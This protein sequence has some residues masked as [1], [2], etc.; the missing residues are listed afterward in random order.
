MKSTRY[1]ALC[2]LSTIASTVGGF[3]LEDHKLFDQRDCLDA[4][5]SSVTFKYRGHRGMGYDNGYSSAAFFFT[6]AWTRDFQP[7]LD[8]RLHIF[9]NGYYASNLGAGIRFGNENNP[10]IFGIN[11]YYDYR[12]W[13]SLE[14]N[15]FGAGIELLSKIFSARLNGYYPI[16][17]KTDV[18]AA[19]FGG[20]RNF[21]I[22]VN[23]SVRAALPSADFEIGAGNISTWEYLD[24][25]VALGSYYLFKQNANPKGIGNALGGRA[26]LDIKIGWL[27]IG[28]EY[29]YDKLFRSRAVAYGN[30][31]IPFGPKKRKKLRW[32]GAIKS[33]S[34]WCKPFRNF[35]DVR[36]QPVQ[37]NEI[38]PMINKEFSIDIKISNSS[39]SL[40][41]FNNIIFVSN[42][43]PAIGAG[44][45]S[46]GNGSF[47]DP[48][49]T[50]AQAQEHS[51]P[52]DM[53]YLLAGNETTD[54]YD[55]G[56][57][58]K[59][60]QIFIGSGNSF[61][62]G[63]VLVPALTPGVN[64]KM[65]NISGSA[66][67]AQDFCTID[68]IDIVNPN[69]AAVAA[70]GKSFVTIQ[71]CNMQGNTLN[72]SVLFQGG[73]GNLTIQ[74]NVITTTRSL[75]DGL[76][77][78]DLVAASTNTVNIL[79]NKITGPFAAGVDATWSNVQTEEASPTFV[80]R[81]N[82][83]IITNNV[84]GTSAQFQSMP[85]SLNLKMFSNTLNGKW[86]PIILADVPQGTFKLTMSGNI[87]GPGSGDT[88]TQP[89]FVNCTNLTADVNISGNY[90]IQSQ[91]GDQL[92]LVFETTGQSSATFNNNHIIKTNTVADVSTA[93]LLSVEN[94][95]NMYIRNNQFTAQKPTAGG[96]SITTLNSGSI[97]SGNT[98]SNFL[99]DL[100]IGTAASPAPKS[101]SSIIN[102]YSNPG[103]K[104]TISG[105]SSSVK[106]VVYVQAG[107]C[108]GDPGL[109]NMNKPNAN[110]ATTNV[111]LVCT[112]PGEYPACSE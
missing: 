53:I 55:T 10:G 85:K 48:Y 102:L 4:T 90:F 110:I 50:L 98:F 17:T 104:A 111:D 47:E 69:G 101:D 31:T 29:T 88:A 68:G 6:P 3:S 63:G 75:A 51:V 81:G 27:T 18:S 38:I 95:R 44:T 65:T 79:N 15:Q 24:A 106:P 12:K 41:N 2:M 82:T 94:S 37:R 64:P 70:V 99:I 26:K 61:N 32:A 73:E 33:S 21:T 20:F 60:G 45:S 25:Y 66:V 40:P 54:G 83:I 93:V 1:I 57:V 9:D 109:K 5:Y 92:N 76:K 80:V 77:F 89:V 62:F 22:F 59:T 87:I 78:T 71:N 16:N 97:I 67:L 34:D 72:P 28:G 91:I 96:I 13:Y 84:E 100:D 23:Q 103:I 36:T 39:G 105:F 112:L 46:S 11:A 108:L 58:M 56:L 19:T 86:G 35:M 30:L 49:S 14:T 42:E 8:A 74:N 52:F 107:N 7:F 43:G